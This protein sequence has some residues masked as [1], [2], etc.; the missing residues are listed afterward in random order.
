MRNIMLLLAMLAVFLFILESSARL[1]KKKEISK[2]R[3]LR[4][5]VISGIFIALIFL[6]IIQFHVPILIGVVHFGD[7]LIFLAATLL[8]PPYSLFVAAL[9]PGLFNLAR[10]PMWFPFTIVIKPLMALCFTSSGEQILGSKRNF[11][12]PFLAVI[13]NTVLYFGGNMFFAGWAGGVGALPGLVIQ[14]VGSIVF[15]FIFAVALDAAK[16]KKLLKLQE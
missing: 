2:R 5:L 13:I 4:L 16:V 9:G 11:I 3:H 1:S 10:I 7:S 12:A 15:F 14:G 8:P 6:T